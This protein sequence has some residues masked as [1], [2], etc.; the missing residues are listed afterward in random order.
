MDNISNAMGRSIKPNIDNPATRASGLLNPERSTNQPT[1]RKHSHRHDT[2]GRRDEPSC[3]GAGVW[4][5]EFAGGMAG[6]REPR[7]PSIMLRPGQ[8][9]RNYLRRH[10]PL[11]TGPGADEMNG[12]GCPSPPPTWT[13]CLPRKA[14]TNEDDDETR[15]R[16]CSRPT[17]RC[18][19]RGAP[20]VALSGLRRRAG[21]AYLTAPAASGVGRRRFESVLESRHGNEAQASRLRLRL[22]PGGGRVR[23]LGMEADSEAARGREGSRGVAQVLALGGGGG[24]GTVGGPPPR[25]AVPPGGAAR[26]GVRV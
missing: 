17:A 18:T 6:R 7:S 21:A 3:S 16:R 19:E 12:N 10:P 26:D 2:S 4:R 15:R 11:T 24:S 14:A 1:N 20:L 13:R 8:R 23:R 22:R 9:R 5:Q 25:G